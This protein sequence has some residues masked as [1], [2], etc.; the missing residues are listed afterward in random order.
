MKGAEFQ[1]YDNKIFL[2]FR[3]TGIIRG[4]DGEG[5]ELFTTDYQFERIPLTDEIRR[6]FHEF[7][8]TAPGYKD[9]YES[10]KHEIK[11]K[12]YYQA[13]QKIVVADKKNLCLNL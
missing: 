4:Y 2:L 7:L 12:D 8:K 9:V 13:V 1:V 11:F 3:E 10:I 6:G 5:N